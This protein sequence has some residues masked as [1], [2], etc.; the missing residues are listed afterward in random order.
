VYIRI[1]RTLVLRTV[2]RYFPTLRQLRQSVSVDRRRHVLCRHPLS[3]WLSADLIKLP[4][5]FDHPVY[6]QRRM[7]SVQNSSVGLIYDLRRCDHIAHALATSHWL[8]VPERVKYTTA[9][10]TFRTL[11]VET[12][13]DI[14]ATDCCVSLLAEIGYPTLCFVVVPSSY[15]EKRTISNALRQSNCCFSLRVSIYV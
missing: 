14:F 7:E 1:A 9:L 13:L 2:S 4:P 15:R 11:R 12:C 10:P 6:L 3:T 8:R 5:R